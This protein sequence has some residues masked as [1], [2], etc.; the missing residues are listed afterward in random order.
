[1]IERV[2]RWREVFVQRECCLNLWWLHFVQ[3]EISR[4]LAQIWWKRRGAR[5]AASISSSH[6]LEVFVEGAC[7][8]CNGAE[9]GFRDVFLLGRMFTLPKEVELTSHASARDAS[10]FVTRYT[11]LARFG[12]SGARAP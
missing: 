4:L 8:D 7:T 2:R 6:H 5:T 10:H 11:W 9:N 1:M 12:W 3:V